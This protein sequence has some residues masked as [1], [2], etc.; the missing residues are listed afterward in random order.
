MHGKEE[1]QAEIPEM[2]TDDPPYL[3]VLMHDTQ[4]WGVAQW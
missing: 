3:S 4:A 2:K 1:V